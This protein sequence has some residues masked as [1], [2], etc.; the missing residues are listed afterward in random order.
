MKLH[1]IDAPADE[2]MC[3]AFV[4]FLKNGGVLVRQ[5]VTRLD[6]T[7]VTLLP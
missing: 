7:S 4:V 1:A 3:L 5:I 6:M 2:S